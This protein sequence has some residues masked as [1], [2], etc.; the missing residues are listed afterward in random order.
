MKVNVYIAVVLLLVLAGV[1]GGISVVV[2]TIGTDGLPDWVVFVVNGLKYVFLTSSAAPLFVIVR[3][4]YGYFTNK[5]AYPNG[6]IQYEGSKLLQTWLVY[7][8]YIKG[9][10]ILVIAFTAGTKLEPVAGLIAGAIAFIVDLIR[11]SLS[12]IAAGRTAPV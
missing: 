10:G 11:K 2:G 1:F 6:Q 4:I 8:S 9:I 3:N 5:A 12:D 7:E